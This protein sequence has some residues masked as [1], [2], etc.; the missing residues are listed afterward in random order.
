MA[1]HRA[2]ESEWYCIKTRTC[3][4]KADVVT[5]SCLIELRDRLEALEARDE[6]DKEAWA[7]RLRRPGRSQAER[8]ASMAERIASLVKRIEALE[9]AQP[10]KSNYPA[11]PDSSL[12]E[13][14]EDAIHRNWNE[15]GHGFRAEARAA[16]R[17]VAKWLS[18]ESSGHLGSGTHW[19][20]R[21]EQEAER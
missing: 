9:A 5:Y 16:I 21:L 10:A 13:R 18:Q 2:T 7:A 15:S 17:E 20:Q 1:E 12:V 11:K 8:I 14:V 6:D 4:D 3:G 19:A